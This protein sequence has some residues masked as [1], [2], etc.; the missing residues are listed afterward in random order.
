MLLALLAQEVTVDNPVAL[1]VV[2]AR[3]SMVSTQVQVAQVATVLS[4]FILG[5]EQQHEIRNS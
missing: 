5:K 3:H 4:V 2:G 1:L